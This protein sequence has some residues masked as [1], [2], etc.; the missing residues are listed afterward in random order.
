VGEQP[1]PETFNKLP[2]NAQMA[3]RASFH[4]RGRQAIEEAREGNKVKVPITP[5]RVRKWRSRSAR[6]GVGTG[7]G[8][9]RPQP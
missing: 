2:E 8:S 9:A 6:A 1:D 7:P 4:A 5:E 3:A